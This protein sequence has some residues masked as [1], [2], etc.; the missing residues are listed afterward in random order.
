[1]LGPRPKFRSLKTSQCSSLGVGLTCLVLMR[2]TEGC[3][4]VNTMC[5]GG[6]TRPEHNLKRSRFRMYRVERL[7]AKLRE[8]AR[9][10]GWGAVPRLCKDCVEMSR[11][12]ASS[13]KLKPNFNPTSIEH[14]NTQTTLLEVEQAEKCPEEGP[15]RHL[16]GRGQPGS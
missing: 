1:M 2:S 5:W 4:G 13:R 6:P 15:G 10:L 9:I 14:Q 16:H 3:K 8:A 12:H 7:G 11:A